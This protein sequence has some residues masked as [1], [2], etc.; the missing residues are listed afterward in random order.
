MMSMKT[1]L[2]SKS[3][4]SLTRISVL[5]VA[6]ISFS[7]AAHAGPVLRAVGPDTPDPDEQVNS[8]GYLKVYSAT[9][10]SESIDNEDTN[11]YPHS[12]YWIYNSAGKRIKTV[13][14][15]GTAPIE[16]PETVELPPGNYIVRA[17]SDND[18]IV[19]V[20]VIIKL[21]RTTAVHLDRS[22][23]SYNDATDPA[24][25]VKAPSMQLDGL[26]A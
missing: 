26:K 22:H 5:A 21:D 3:L 2:L 11:F 24:G 8:C 25:E 4:S 12:A 7:T 10:A 17:W 19:T 23:L 13:Q 9:D 18:G 15:H 14:N 16:G 6:L 1:N 20:P